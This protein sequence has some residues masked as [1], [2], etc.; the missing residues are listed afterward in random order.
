MSSYTVEVLDEG[1]IILMTMGSDYNVVTDMLKSSTECFDLL[2]KGPERIVFI[3]DA[4]EVQLKGLDEMLHGAQ[5]MM[6][7]EISKITHHPKLAKS[8]SVTNSKVMRAAVK[9]L[10]TLTFGFTEL[11]VFETVEEALNYARTV[12]YGQSKAN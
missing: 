2:E 8:L 11:T 3:T 10:N 1:R 5:N 4:R 9:G 12:L 7:P 6:N